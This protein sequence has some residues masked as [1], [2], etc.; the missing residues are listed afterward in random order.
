[1]IDLPDPLHRYLESGKVVLFLGAGASL[2]ASDSAGNPIAGSQELARRLSDQFL[3]GQHR[4]DTLSFVSEL[5]LGQVSLTEFELFVHSVFED[6]QPTTA[7]LLI[8]TLRWAGIVTTNYD[9]I[10]ERSYSKSNALQKLFI[11]V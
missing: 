11:S 8:P 7:H 6:A 4:D 10:V 3:G 1:M 2:G 5:C 9:S